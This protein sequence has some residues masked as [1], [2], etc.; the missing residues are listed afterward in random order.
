MK[1]K[2]VVVHEL[3]RLVVEEVELDE[4]RSDELLVRLGATGVCH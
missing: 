3:G 2:A 4:P 1:C